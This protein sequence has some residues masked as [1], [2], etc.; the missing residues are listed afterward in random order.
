LSR[1]IP[2]PADVRASVCREFVGVVQEWVRALERDATMLH[3]RG[4]HR[5]AAEC[6]TMAREARRVL[7]VLV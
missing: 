3:L 2:A 5:F 4:C 7:E 6:K 1:S